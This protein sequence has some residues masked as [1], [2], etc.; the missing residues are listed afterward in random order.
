MGFG[1]KSLGSNACSIYYDFGQVTKFLSQIFLTCEVVKLFSRE[2]LPV[3]KWIVCKLAWKIMNIE[4]IIVKDT[5]AISTTIANN[6][7]L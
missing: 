4:T 1:F 6:L 5:S 2:M 3:L 7:L